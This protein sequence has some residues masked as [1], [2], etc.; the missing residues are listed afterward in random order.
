VETPPAVKVI[1]K[2]TII[3]IKPKIVFARPSID[4]TKSSGGSAY[5]RGY[6]RKDGKCVR[7][8]YRRKRK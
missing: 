8:Y 1:E 7:G 2:K 3:Q 6:C 4:K 5:V